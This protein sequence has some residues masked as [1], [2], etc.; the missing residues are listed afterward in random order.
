MKAS[1]EVD[2]R[3]VGVMDEN[4]MLAQH[5]EEVDRLVGAASRGAAGSCGT[6]GGSCRSGRSMA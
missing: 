5:R 6:H 4:V 1:T 2:E 3:V